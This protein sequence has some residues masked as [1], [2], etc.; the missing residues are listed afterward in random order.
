MPV[1]VTREH[2]QEDD[3]IGAQLDHLSDRGDGIVVADD[4]VTAL[5]DGNTCF[6]VPK[7]AVGESVVDTREVHP[8]L[9]GT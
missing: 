3:T 6:C 4:E 5:V 1:S 7:I 8:H 9:P 2:L